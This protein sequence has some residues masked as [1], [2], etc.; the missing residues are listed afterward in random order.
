M[1]SILSLVGIVLIILGIVSLGYQGFS[2]TQ[3]EKVVE[4][5]SL[6][7]TADTTKTVYLSPVVGVA[8]LVGGIFLVLVGR[9]GGK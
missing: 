9:R 6:Q 1:K 4:V 7:V 8:A 2:Y 3:R 5:G